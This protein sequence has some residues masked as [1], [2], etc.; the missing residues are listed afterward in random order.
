MDQR[1]LDSLP[2]K[3]ESLESEIQRLTD[4]MSRPEFFQQDRD[5]IVQCQQQL[6]RANSD[7]DA[8]FRRWEQL[9]S[10]EF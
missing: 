5:A 8:C 1:E 10:I 9:E 7:L 6:E 3:I 4:E 2:E